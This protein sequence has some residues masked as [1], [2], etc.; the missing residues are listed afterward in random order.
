[1]HD[2]RD[3]GLFVRALTTGVDPIGRTA[4]GMFVGVA[5]STGRVELAASV[6][7]SRWRSWSVDATGGQTWDFAG[8]ASAA[9]GNAVP[10]SFRERSAEVGVRYRWRRWRS[11]ASIRFGAFVEQDALVN[12]GSEPLGFSPANRTYAGS[13]VSVGAS[14]FERPALAISPENGGSVVALALRR[15][16]VAG[17]G[18]SHEFRVGVNGY[19]ALP[20]P[21]FAH[22]VLAARATAG[23]TA[24][25]TP[26]VYSVGGVSGDVVD[27]LPGYTLGSGRRKFPLRGYERGSERFTRAFVGVLELRVPVAAVGRGVPKLPLLLDRVSLAAFGEI[28]GGWNAGEAVALS[29]YRDVGGE[30]VIDTGV[31]NV[32]SLRLRA[33]AAVAL[34]DGL[35]QSRGDGRLYLTAGSAF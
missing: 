19:L 29:S 14:R 17:P 27:L 25:P 31:G 20:L 33:G 34:T 22:W 28:G 30:I 35:G 26:T 24:G 7:H 6:V 18:W 5:P 10:V 4:Y 13:V 23:V 9:S 11:G 32:V 2:E 3:A 16:Q 8:L 1:M 15:E 12:D 21:G